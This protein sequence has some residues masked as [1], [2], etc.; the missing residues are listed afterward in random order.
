MKEV[1]RI[2]L[3]S[4]CISDRSYLQYL[5][6]MDATR[7]GS[8]NGLFNTGDLAIVFSTVQKTLSF[9]EAR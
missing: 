5:R 6:D 9:P 7:K 8:K 3:N 4:L 1:R 2:A